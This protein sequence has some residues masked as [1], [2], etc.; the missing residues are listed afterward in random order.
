[1]SERLVVLMTTGSQEEAETIA[2][3]LVKTMLAACVN[4]IPGMTSIY[5]WED[6]VQRDA[7]WLLLA[8]TRHEVLEDLVQHV[9]T[10]HSYDVPE[11]VALPIIGGHEAYLLW[12]DRETHGDW[13]AMD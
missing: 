2:H 11:V 1:M 9:R 6:E 10:L 5:R 4:I 8:K 7:E 12:L 3:S 13:H